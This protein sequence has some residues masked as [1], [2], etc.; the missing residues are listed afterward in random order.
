M[1]LEKMIAC[2]LYDPKWFPNGRL[3]I[4]SFKGEI[5]RD[6]PRTYIEINNEKY[7]VKEYD[8][9]DT[10]QNYKIADDF[11]LKIMNVL[12]T[13]GVIDFDLVNKID[14]LVQ[15]SILNFIVDLIHSMITKKI[16]PEPYAL[17]L[18]PTKSISINLTKDEQSITAKL[19]SRRLLMSYN[20]EIPPGNTCGDVEFILLI[21]L[22]RNTYKFTKFILKYDNEKCNP[23]SDN[24]PDSDNVPVSDNQPENNNEENQGNSLLKYIPVGLGIGGIAATP[25]ILGALGGKNKKL[26]T[27]KRKNKR[28]KKK[29]KT[30]KRRKSF[31]K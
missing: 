22:K 24:Q 19:Q 27:K 15:Q 16:T 8:K 1:S 13:F 9:E 3:N 14:I 21:D 18:D 30:R 29:N 11:N 4:P 31:Y 28:R 7:N 26:K 20:G 25:F 23:D 12:S 6:V 10:M 2:I 17:I 5:G